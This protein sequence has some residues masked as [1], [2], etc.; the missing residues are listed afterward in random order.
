ME[1]IERINVLEGEV[2]LVKSEI[3]KVLID[4]REAMN[5]LENPFA[6]IEPGGPGISIGVGGVGGPAPPNAGVVAPQSE[7]EEVGDSSVSEP[8]PEPKPRS[9][10]KSEPMSVPNPESVPEP[11]PSP[12]IKEEKAAI[13]DAATELVPE[14]TPGVVEENREKEKIKKLMMVTGSEGAEEIDINTL[15]QLMK[16]TDDTLSTIGKNKLNEILDLYDRTGQ[17]S[18]GV[19]DLIYRIEEISDVNHAKEIEEVEMKDCIIAVDQLDTI[20]TGETETPVPLLL[21]EED[22]E[23]CQK[24]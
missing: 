23:K 10:P 2:K 16:W 7:S 8:N 13:E 24:V 19:K 1:L 12:E 4:L 9:I 20:I 17:L 11:K 21:S 15:T 14:V 18:K 5:N 6:H 3:K 22:L